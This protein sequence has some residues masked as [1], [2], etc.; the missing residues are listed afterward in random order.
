MKTYFIH[1][2]GH[3]DGYIE[4]MLKANDPKEAKKFFLDNFDLVNGEVAAVRVWELV[5]QIC[6]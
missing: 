6:E 1:A 2:D 5:E 3:P 4:L